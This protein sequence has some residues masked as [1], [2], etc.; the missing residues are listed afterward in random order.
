MMYTFL[1]LCALLVVASASERQGMT[2]FQKQSLSLALPTHSSRILSLL[3]YG[4][5]EIEQFPSSSSSFP[6][7]PSSS[8]SSSSRIPIPNFPSSSSSSFPFPPSSSGSSIP[9]FPSLLPPGFLAVMLCMENIPE[10]DVACDLAEGNAAQ[11]CDGTSCFNDFMDS[12]TGMI[13]CLSLEPSMMALIPP[14]A[15]N[16]D[17]VSQTFDA[18]CTLDYSG[19]YC[20]DV[21]DLNEYE[22]TRTTCSQLDNYGCC[23]STAFTAMSLVNTSYTTAEAYFSQCDNVA[24]ACLAAGKSAT[25]A[26]G[27]VSVECL[28]LSWVE[29]C[30]DYFTCGDTMA[31]ALSEDIAA[32]AGINQKYVYISD[33]NATESGVVYF[34]YVIGG[35]S[36]TEINDAVTALDASVPADWTFSNSV[37]ATS[38]YPYYAYSCS[39][40]VFAYNDTLSEQ[41]AAEVMTSESIEFVFVGSASAAVPS[42]L[43]LLLLAV[44]AVFA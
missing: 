13:D 30:Y 18:Y 27:S 20:G 12:V 11:A 4:S 38:A 21:V 33:F 31:Q 8:S 10:P 14:G 34:D 40:Q 39:G 35:A 25:V 7:I 28:S 22:I 41:A 44:A 24:P 19:R 43:V 16:L 3:N 42:F 32:V 37:A 36:A 29:G 23:M 5:N 1:S 6:S 2:E 17:I 9:S 26:R 15:L